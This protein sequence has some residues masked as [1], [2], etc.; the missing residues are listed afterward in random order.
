MENSGGYLLN[1]RLREIE[2]EI[3]DVYQEIAEMMGR[4]PYASKVYALFLIHGELTQE[5]IREIT[6]NSKSYVSSTLKFL[7]NAGTLQKEFVEGTHTLIYRLS[8]PHFHFQYHSGIAVQT[9]LKELHAFILSLLDRVKLISEE[10]QENVRF[11]IKRMN[12]LLNYTHLQELVFTDGEPNK[13]LDESALNFMSNNKQSPLG[14][15]IEYSPQLRIL[16]DELARYLDKTGIVFYRAPTLTKI[17]TFFIT[18]GILTQ[19][20]LQSLLNRSIG[21]ISQNLSCLI[22][23]VGHQTSEERMVS[24]NQGNE[25][26]I[27][28]NQAENKLDSLQK[29]HGKDFMKFHNIIEKLP[30]RQMTQPTL[31]SLD[32]VSLVFVDLIMTTDERIFTI[33]DKIKRYAQEL[34]LNREKYGKD[35]GYDKIASFLNTFI[36]SIDILQSDHEKLRSYRNHLA[37]FLGKPERI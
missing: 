4:N 1:G 29:G 19:E 20:M 18:R 28:P 16:E 30:K 25:N 7:L 26:S 10:S 13:W 22:N 21:S 36:Q 6:Q 23:N 32:S 34:E 12:S 33:G 27:R 11:F 8:N 14:N 35:V 5:Q 2:L 17:L 37:R 3:L 31:Y 15:L 9:R 24:N